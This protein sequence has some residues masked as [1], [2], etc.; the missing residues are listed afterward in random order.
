M[1]K[2]DLHP[3]VSSLPEVPDYKFFKI[4]DQEFLGLGTYF[5]VLEERGELITAVSPETFEGTEY[6][7]HLKIRVSRGVDIY[8]GM[9]EED[10]QDALQIGDPW[11][12]FQ[13]SNFFIRK[14]LYSYLDE[15]QEKIL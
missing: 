9:K 5:R 13:T 7:R 2:T 15:T 4:T 14:R 11:K 8:I 10:Y 12:Y 1:K 3:G 6:T